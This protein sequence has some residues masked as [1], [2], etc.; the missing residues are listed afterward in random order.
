[1]QVL[2]FVIQNMVA[3]HI[4]CDGYSIPDQVCI[5]FDLVTYPLLRA[6]IKRGFTLLPNITMATTI[7]T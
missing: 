1:M 7:M 6:S 3:E 4:T 2:V 5:L